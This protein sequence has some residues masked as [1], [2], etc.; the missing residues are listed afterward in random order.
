MRAYDS[1][2]T[3]VDALCRE[4]RHSNTQAEQRQSIQIRTLSVR[5]KEHLNLVRALLTPSVSLLT[6]SRTF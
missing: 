3:D 2:P 4:V 1:V 6:V 5:V